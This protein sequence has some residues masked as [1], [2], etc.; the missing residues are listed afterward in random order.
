MDWT[1][2]DVAELPH[3]ARQRLLF[4]GRRMRIVELSLEVF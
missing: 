4:A 1:S 2:A 3:R